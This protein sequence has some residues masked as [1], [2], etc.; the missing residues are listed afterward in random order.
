M[1]AL[2]VEPPFEIFTDIDGQPL[3]AGFVWIG[4]ANLDPQ[5]N[6]I[7][8]YFDQALTIPAGQPL[9]TLGGYIVNSGTP[10]RIYVNAV[11]Y[12]IRVMNKN[13]S[14]LYTLLNATGID[15]NA[16]GIAYDP[17]FTDSV[18]TT[19]SDKL[20]QTVSVEDFGAVG[21]G[22]TDDTVTIQN[23]L[24]SGVKEIV[25]TSGRTYLI[26][27]GLVS[28]TA[29]QV[30]RAYGATI[31]LKNSATTKGMLRLNGVGSS[32]MGGTWDGNKANGN[33]GPTSVST[34][35]IEVYSS[36]NIYIFADRCTVRDCYSINT[37][38][39]FCNGGT[40]SDTLFENN[41]I[42]NTF[43]Y[44]LFLSTGSVNSYRN[45]AI[46]NNIDMSEGGVV[47]QGI[48]FTGAGGGV[49]VK[50]FDW[51]ISNNTVIG[52]QDPAM[53]DLGINLAVRGSRGIVSNNITRY[54]SMGWSEG[55]VDTV[56]TGNSFLDMVGSVRYGIEISGKNVTVSG[57]IVSNAI[58]GIIISGSS[59]DFD[60]LCITGNR[61]QSTRDGIRLQA[62]T[63]TSAKNISITGN[64]I[65]TALRGVITTGDIVNLT[66]TSNVIVGPGSGTSGSRGVYLENPP[67]D[68]FVFVQGNT[69]ASVQRACS[70]FASSALAV[71]KLYATGN[72]I[73]NDTTSSSR[74]WNFEGSATVGTDVSFAWG[75]TNTGLRDNRLDGEIK[76][77]ISTGSPEG[78]LTAAVGSLYLRSNGGA[79]T[80][81]YVKESG[82]GNTGWVAK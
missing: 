20:A 59:G 47:G 63:G 23:A 46:G 18:S 82:T 3:E 79:N 66:I 28:N 16:S 56:I 4:A 9:R 48:L 57:N 36:W 50:Q 11:A 65:T 10:A 68:A 41:T 78:V 49:A 12:S 39:M 67:A 52:S 73:S 51:E 43:G 64:N 32:V 8:V 5:T 54:G 7:N 44:G 70:V 26:D 22:T 24:D 34:L 45:R 38:G 19:V 55:G 74:A 30:I 75:P 33:S 13:G 81:L 80:T 72:N 31:K 29:G 69:I 40:V 6:P 27:G 42:R 2:I 76:F 71:N 77:N 37:Y 35:P 53:V 62:G 25:F 15:P 17:P 58:N 14:T 60:N 61:I 1:S 21:N